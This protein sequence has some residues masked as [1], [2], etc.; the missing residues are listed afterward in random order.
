MLPF[1]FLPGYYLYLSVLQDKM[2]AAEEARI[3]KLQGYFRSFTESQR[4]ITPIINKCLEGMDLA[5]D[6]CDP[7]KVTIL[8]TH[9]EQQII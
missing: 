6:I 5:A 9:W 7:K 2:Q 4:V 1:L 8:F 3:A